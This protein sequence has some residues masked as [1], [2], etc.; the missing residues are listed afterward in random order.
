MAYSRNGAPATHSSEPSTAAMMIAVPRSPPS[1]TRTRIRPPTGSIG[2]SRCFHW[3]SSRSLRASR[4]APQSTS[5][6]FASSDGWIRNGPPKSSQFLLPLTS[7]PATTTSTSSAS[8][9][10]SAG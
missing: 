10:T 3:P 9:V 5:D 2:T 7:V 8:E 1:R 4:S 6:S